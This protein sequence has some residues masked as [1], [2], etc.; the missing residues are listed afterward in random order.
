MRFTN[1]CGMLGNPNFYGD[2]YQAHTAEKI[3]QLKAMNVN[4]VF[5]NIAWSRPW[6]DAVN[7]ENT[8]VSASFPLLSDMDEVERHRRGLGA[9]VRAVKAAGLQAFALF[10]IPRY[11]DFSQ[12]PESYSVLRGSTAS[13]ISSH[14]SVACVRSPEVRQLYRE[15]FADLL[16]HMPEL[17]GMLVYT[18]DELAEV[19][20]ED[21]D[22]PRC[23]GIP[24][25]ERIP[26]FLNG[27]YEDLQALKPGF[28]LWWEPWELSAAQTYR[29]EERLNAAIGLALHSTLHEV[30]F[31][32]ET[33]QW[34]RNLAAVA[35]D[36]GRKV[37]GEIFAGG[38]GEDLGN[39]VG[40]PSPRLVY[41]QIQALVR[42]P[43]VT[44]MKEYFGFPLEYAS[45]N[46]AAMRLV[47]QDPNRAWDSVAAALAADYA[48]DADGRQRIRQFWECAARAVEFIPWELSWVLRFGNLPPYAE[49]WG[50][51]F[52]ELFKTPWS[53]PSWLSNRRSFYLVVD[54]ETNFTA[55]MQIDLIERLRMA[56]D[57]LER[58]AGEAGRAEVREGMRAG[59]GLQLEAVAMLGHMVKCRLHHLELSCLADRL[60]AGQEE[61]GAGAA[62]RRIA[63]LLDAERDNAGRWLRLLQHSDVPYTF[64]SGDGSALKQETI[65]ATIARI[66]EAKALLEREDLVAWLARYF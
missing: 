40:Y 31:V 7:L 48:A 44:G 33:D 12:Y 59:L 10:G 50:T 26:T 42:L 34:F 60:R 6:V 1:V 27:L 36:R 62:V 5:V 2:P 41:Q 55:R 51:R 9:R 15:L 61:P 13:T 45:V 37:I 8:A 30:Y 46:E 52:V 3:E 43:G 14:D 21:S 22:C 65:A 53:T 19:C 56:A 66:E 17:D 28:E 35:S 39:I 20:D 29:I 63:S 57:W 54:G 64:R 4:T 23:R 58:A 32:N 24:A 18:Y 49:Y 25:E 16:A 38:S 47:L 11:F